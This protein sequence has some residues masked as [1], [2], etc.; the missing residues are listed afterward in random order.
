MEDPMGTATSA[1]RRYHEA[2]KHS[3][4]SVRSSVHTLDWANKPLAFKIYTGLDAIP[5]PEDIG[6]LCLYTNGVL[7]WRRS[8]D[9]Q[10]Y[11]FRAG[12][13]TG[14]LYHIELYLAT[15]E[16]PDLPAGLYHYG[17]HDHA[18]RLLRTGDVRGALL[19]ASGGFEP[20]VAAPLVLVLTSTFWRNSWKYQARA[21]RHTY[22]DSGVILANLLALAAADRSPT[23]VVLGFA[24]DEVHR[25]LGVDGE[26]E[27]AVALVA[28]GDGA[29]VPSARLSLP[30]LDLSTMPL[31]ARR[32]RYPEIEEAH[33]ASSLPS[34]EAVAAWRE[35]T[36]TSPMAVPQPLFDSPVAKVIRARRSARHFGRAAITRGQ[37]ESVLAAARR[38]IPGDSVSPDLV[39]PF[40][41][42]NAVEGLEPGAYGPTAQLIK[43]G[44]YRHRAGELDLGQVLG[45]EAAANI[46]FM[47]D[48]DAVLD[49]LGERGYGVA[50]MAGGIA[51]GRVELSATAG[52]FGAT[53]LTFFDDEVTQFFEPEAKGRQVMFLA[54][55]G[56]LPA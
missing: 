37:L 8:P 38:P 24:D 26:L 40:L 17:A 43:A 29:P 33:R 12:A 10:V 55:L 44:D 25:L 53:G 32:V 11:G 48:L 27:A 51:G 18:L 5:P 23:S 20:L 45:A 16:R 46:Y 35:S 7:R 39:E 21:Y 34:G 49:R 30:E 4:A 6:R 19:E 14:A 22:W 50:Q 47:S 54:A 41:I 52:G 56:H 15:A 3:L 2:T 1:L 13:C 36:Q 28:L 9:S 31:S 42:V